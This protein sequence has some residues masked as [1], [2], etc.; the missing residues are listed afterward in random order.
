MLPDFDT[1]VVDSTAHTLGWTESA[2]GVTP[3]FAIASFQAGRERVPPMLNLQWEWNVVAPYGG[4]SIPM[5]TLPTDIADFAV[6]AS[7]FTDINGVA[8]GKVPGGY[9][10]VR[11]NLFNVDGIESFATS[12]TGS[13]TVAQWFQPKKARSLPQSRVPGFVT[14]IMRDRAITTHRGK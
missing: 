11:A 13:M 2:T 14:G 12:A 7:D 1:P 5:P 6:T 8:L 10:A 9:D 3:D 4:A